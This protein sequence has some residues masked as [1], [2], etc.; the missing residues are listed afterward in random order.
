MSQELEAFAL[1]KQ[2]AENLQGRGSNGIEMLQQQDGEVKRKDSELRAL[3]RALEEGG[4]EVGE[5]EVS[6]TEEPGT[7]TNTVLKKEL[8]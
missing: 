2:H 3:K 6:K 4:V 8:E 7:P 5:L 1:F